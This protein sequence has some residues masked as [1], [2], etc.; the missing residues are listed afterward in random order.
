MK[1][2]DPEDRADRRLRVGIWTAAIIALLLPIWWNIVETTWAAIVLRASVQALAQAI[3]AQQPP[4][5][6]RAP[7]RASTP[8]PPPSIR[9][10]GA[11]SAGSAVSVLVDL[12]G[13]MPEPSRDKICSDGAA[14][15]AHPL[16]GQ[17]VRILR[18][19][20]TQPASDAGTII[21]R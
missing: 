17:T 11:T 5:P 8:P 19:H 2:S 1:W 15:I 6:Y 4:A 12:A 18:S 13:T 21:C 3:P 9:V 14:F 10:L 20:G 16:S 7:M